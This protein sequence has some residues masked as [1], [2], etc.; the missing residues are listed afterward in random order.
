MQSRLML[1]G[2]TKRRRVGIGSGEEFWEGGIPRP[3]GSIGGHDVWATADEIA[4]AVGVTKQR[5][6]QLIQAVC[7]SLWREPWRSC[8]HADRAGDD[9]CG[10][11]ARMA[12]EAMRRLRMRSGLGE[13]DDPD[14]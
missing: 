4:R 1:P 13:C 3:V 14:C 11:C 7:R 8:R 12:H 9:F 5:T 10:P 6:D 2:M